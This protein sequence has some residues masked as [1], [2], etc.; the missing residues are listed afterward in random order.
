MKFI[1]YSIC[2]LLVGLLLSLAVVYLFRANVVVAS[3]IGITGSDGAPFD[4]TQQFALFAVVFE[5]FTSFLFGAYA[6]DHKEKVGKT[7]KPHE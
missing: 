7:N 4:Y 6:L 2:G 1:I 3:F 5:C